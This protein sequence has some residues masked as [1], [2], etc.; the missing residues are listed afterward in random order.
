[1]KFEVTFLR[2]K[3]ARR[4]FFLFVACA[5][6][7]IAAL[8]ILSFSLVTNQLTKQSQERLQ[9]GSRNIGHGIV[10]RLLSIQVE[11]EMVAS[12]LS[13]SP[14]QILN[15]PSQESNEHLK[16]RFKGLILIDG[17]NKS[18]VLFG[19]IP[20]APRLSQDDRQNVLSGKPGL[21]TKVEPEKRARIFMYIAIYSDQPRQEILLAEINPDHFWT[22]WQKFNLQKE[23][24]LSVL[25]QSDNLL[26][27]T[28]DFPGAFP[29]RAVMSMNNAHS[30]QFEWVYEKEKYL[31]S[32]WGIFLESRF[33]A[34]DWTVVF[35]QTKSSV[36]WVNFIFALVFP[37]VILVSLWVV[38]LL[39]VSQIRK[40]LIPLEKLKEGTKRIARR[41][42]D[43]RVKVTS[44]DE[45]EEV[46]ESFNTM[47]SQL[48]RQF[49]TLTTITEIDR[50]ILSS[51]DKARIIDTVLARMREVFPCDGVS[52][53]L[54]E[55]NGAETAKTYVE[56]CKSDKRK[57]E[58]TI[59]LRPEEIE[60]LNDNP[61]T[62]LIEMDGEPPSYLAPMAK[63][64]IKSILVL[65]IFLQ[66][67]LSGIIALGYRKPPK[68]EQEDLDQARQLA[69]QVAVAFSN[70]RL[71]EELA[72]LNWGTLRA[73]AR[74]I[75]AKS[76]WTAGHS[77]RST[78]LA[79]QIGRVLRL[80]KEELDDLHR[81]GLLHDIGKLG[82]PL[83]VL[84]K[85]GK[86]TAEER[87]FMQNHPSMGARILEPISAYAEV[88]PIVLQHHE[89]FDGSGYP[90][91]LSGRAISFGARILAL[92]DRFEALT[93]DRPY[94]KALNL[95]RTIEYIRDR[96]GSEFDPKIVKAFLKVMAQ[97]E[98]K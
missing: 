11:M 3:V 12:N 66:Q 54:F 34:D 89:S 74:A 93:S 37:L 81:A 28:L 64:G 20:D 58:K 95:K 9:Q 47:A 67:E 30:A 75:D 82:I 2:S 72:E 90:D 6:I 69:D 83:D 45:F 88:I 29:E 48:G 63:L 19:L 23:T 8:A 10:E 43:S 98:K 14:T 50:A 65:P 84:D 51:L 77:E 25:D 16:E 97:E 59:E 33:Y 61:D 5:L 13:A 49:K 40:S 91:G 57:Q 73:L 21:F 32:F 35:S 80:N 36:L 41:E 52:V 68:F 86:L 1:M 22:P 17:D 53:T 31:A 27:S 42:F 71:I 15:I 79:L 56:D 87:Q 94:R 62:I 70:A 96:A 55:S 60:E 24:E 4:I 38:S 46:A 7:P 39:S 26:Y 78:K 18:K 85:N 92:A 76:P 44:R